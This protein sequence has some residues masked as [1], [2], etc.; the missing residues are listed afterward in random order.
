LNQGYLRTQADKESLSEPHKEDNKGVTSSLQMGN[1]IFS[2]NKSKRRHTETITENT[3][4]TISE[5]QPIKRRKTHDTESKQPS[6]T[7]TIQ[8]IEMNNQSK[9]PFINEI[10]ALKLTPTASTK[11]FS[12][13][14]SSQL[15]NSIPVSLTFSPNHACMA[16][17]YEDLTLQV[18]PLVHFCPSGTTCTF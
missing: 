1:F 16:I 11:H 18:I 10:N 13:S 17:L 5:E 3:V 8:L 14:T 12:S 9:E 7:E 15:R 4:N 6:T 2:T